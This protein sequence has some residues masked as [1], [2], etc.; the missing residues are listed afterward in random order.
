M[1]LVLD[2]LVLILLREVNS[3]IANVLLAFT[4]SR[5]FQ[6]EMTEISDCLIPPINWVHSM[7][8]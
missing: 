7:G 1:M 5:V 4:S 3:S 6:L 8:P 2:Y